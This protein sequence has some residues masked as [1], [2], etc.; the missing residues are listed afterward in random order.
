MAG[1]TSRYLRPH[2]T[3]SLTVKCTGQIAEIEEGRVRLSPWRYSFI[4]R[5]K[6]RKQSRFPAEGTLNKA[7]TVKS[8]INNILHRIGTALLGSVITSNRPA[9][10][11]QLLSLLQQLKDRA[12][13]PLNKF[14]EKYF[15]QFDEDGITLEILRRVGLNTGTFAELGVGNGSENNTLILLA[16]GFRGFWIGGE[17]LFFNRS[18][19][20]SRFSFLKRWIDK[21]NVVGYLQEGLGSIQSE[22]LDIISLDLD[23][24]DIY[25][26]EKILENGIKPKLFIVEYNAKFPPPIRWKIDYDEAHH[27]NGDDYFGASLSSFDDLFIKHGYTLICC[28]FSGANAFFIRNDLLH[29]FND[30]PRDMGALFYGPRYYLFQAYGH[31]ASARTIEQILRNPGNT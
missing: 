8:A 15:S 26:A 29:H 22:A 2:R 17:D 4:H 24:N 3:A 16:K 9:H 31:K 7:L 28:N 1:E 13:N 23:G 21:D 10:D 14:G 5:G 6:P 18:P 27:W 11:I 19:A 20:Q 12:S 30:V 25:V